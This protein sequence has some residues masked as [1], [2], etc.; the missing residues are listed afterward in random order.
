MWSIFANLEST[1]VFRIDFWEFSSAVD[2]GIVD[3]DWI[4]LRNDFFYFFLN[5][6]N[7]FT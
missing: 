4:Y 5:T 3:S 2:V 7:N 6:G 1:L